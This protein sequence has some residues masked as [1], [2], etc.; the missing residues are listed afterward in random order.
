MTFSTLSIAFARNRAAVLLPLLCFSV[1]CG[2]KKDGADGAQGGGAQGADGKDPGGKDGG[3]PKILPYAV[4]KVAPRTTVLYNDFPATIQGQQNVEI[5]PKV[6]GFVEAIYV[7]EGAAV[8]KGQPL[9]HISAPQY[10][11][12]VRTAQAGIQTAVADVNTARM[13][14][15]KLRHLVKMTLPAPTR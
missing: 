9:F 14:V 2:S 7:D 13:G 11:E 10:E 6:D 15:E 4:V 5:R 8:R 12:A 1:A 3:P